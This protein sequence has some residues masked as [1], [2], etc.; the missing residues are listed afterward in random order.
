MGLT[1]ENFS[2][3]GNIPE[4]KERLHIYTKGELIVFPQA[5][6]TVVESSSYPKPLED[7]KEF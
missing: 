1:I 2:L 4:A 3:E 6:N 5:F 7:L